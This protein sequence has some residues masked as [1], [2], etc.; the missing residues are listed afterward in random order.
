M[1]RKPLRSYRFGRANL[2]THAKPS[3]FAHLPP[4]ANLRDR[5]ALRPITRCRLLVGGRDRRST[6]RFLPWPD[7][8]DQRL[9]RRKY[10]VL[11]AIHR[12]KVHVAF[13]FLCPMLLLPAMLAES[14][15]AQSPISS[16]VV[17]SK[18]GRIHGVT[19]A[20]GV[21]SRPAITSTVVQASVGST[22][23]GKAIRNGAQNVLGVLNRQR[24]R[25]GLRSLRYD[26]SL[27]AVAQRRVRQMASTGMKSHPPGSFAP[28]RYEGVGW[29]SSFSPSGV[30]AC[31]T[32]DP[33]M[34]AA[35]AAMA[36]GR[37]GV[38][39]AVVYR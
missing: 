30:H 20:T 32:S 12:F 25:Q 39:F 7:L 4:S 3:R 34:T 6:A 16:G 21:V 27:Q 23:V 33:N 29:S 38:Y 17:C 31:Y 36:T 9:R 35:G 28:G 18:C 14:V 37:D 1:D 22:T 15:S 26:A 10:V 19:R 24:S 2:S 8:P 5:D 13:V 11:L